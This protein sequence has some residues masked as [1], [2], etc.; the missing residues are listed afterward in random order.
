[1]QDHLKTLFLLLVA[2]AVWAQNTVE[3][4]VVGKSMDYR[5][6]D[7]QGVLLDSEESD[8]GDITGVEAALTHSFAHQRG[9]YAKVELRL[10]RLYGQSVY[11]GS[12]LGS[13]DPYGSVV[14]VTDNTV[15]QGALMLK[16]VYLLSQSVNLKAGI[17]IGKYEWERT[18]SS[19]QNE[20]YTWYP[21]ELLAGGS[22]RFE[23][24]DAF[25]FDG[26]LFYKRGL[27]PVMSATNIPE[28]FKLGGVE[29]YGFR[30]HLLYKL[31]S[32][33]HLVLGYEYEY[34]KIKRSNVVAG[35]YYE[36]DSEDSRSTLKAGLQY[37]F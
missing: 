6:Y 13:G 23:E 14:S 37:A 28:E 4:F 17:G 10:S 25:D 36:P 18:L 26:E 29:C 30:L 20:I 2:S 5:E 12:V 35:G 33:L 31:E 3:L 16:G 19:I 8:Y 7:I 32:R 27:S 11:K 15:T 9:F 1:M 21:L 24:A 22:F 34:Q